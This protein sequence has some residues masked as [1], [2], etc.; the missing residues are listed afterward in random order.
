MPQ[1]RAVL[2]GAG[3]SLGQATVQQQAR[4][5]S[6]NSNALTR[7][8]GTADEQIEAPAALTRALG[9]IDEYA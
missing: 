5:E 4:R 9:M 1:L 2:A 6:Q 7:A 3:L 8:S